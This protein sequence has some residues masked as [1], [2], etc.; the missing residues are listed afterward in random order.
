M[1]LDTRNLT[2]SR[3]SILRLLFLVILFCC[4]AY[5]LFLPLSYIFHGMSI[6][7]SKP[8]ILEPG[9]DAI[10]HFAGSRECGILQ[11]DV[12]TAPWPL[13]PKVS[14]FCGKRAGLLEALSGGG[15][16]GFDEPFVGKDCTYRWFSTPEIC[17]VIER[18]N[19]ITFVGDDIAQSIYSAFNILLR[20]DL[21]L[22]G[23]QQW[24]MS[25]E[26]KAKC[27]CHNQFLDIECQRFAVKSSDDVKKNDSGDRKGSPYFCDS[28]KK[29]VP[30]EFISV[31]SVPTSPASQA[32]YED[33]TYGKSNPWQP[34][35]MIF[36]FGHGS[37][38]D[39]GIAT[40]AI[41]EWSTLA[42]G[43]ERNIPMLF[44]SPPA[45]G[46]NK[47]PSSAPRTGNLAAWN[48]HTEMAP[49]AKEKHFDVL[50]LYNLTLQ[51][52]SVDGERFGE[53]VALV[54]AM[55]IINWL[56]KLETS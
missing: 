44:I 11:E 17:M 45:F 36:S 14:P 48:F 50:S 43:A 5:I 19:A 52:S 30:H 53:E 21:A 3:A 55:M 10:K 37:A 23:L 2:S 1:K 12:Y 39:T 33:L 6:H 7:N 34:S 38:F 56:S 13:D 24:T 35:P 20:E 54:Q 9:E 31:N 22:G 41:D 27:R 46:I 25:D 29:D 26:D 15:R 32:N 49:V 4:G 51:A 18:F 28:E 16:Y 42:T 40:R 8:V 47:A